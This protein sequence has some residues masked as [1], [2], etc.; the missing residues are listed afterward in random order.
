M[1]AEM[2]RPCGYV[3]YPNVLSQLRL[4]PP[5]EPEKYPP[6]ESC[7]I[8]Q[9]LDLLS[10]QGIENIDYVTNNGNI[11]V[12]DLTDEVRDRFKNK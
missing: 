11:A 6:W 8:E 5:I 1:K 4:E 12:E 3:R 7:T 9:R 10:L 2:T